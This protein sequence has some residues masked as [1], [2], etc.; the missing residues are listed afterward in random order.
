MRSL[1]ENLPVYKKAQDLVIY[2][3]KIVC[4]FSRYHKYTVG[5]ELRNLSRK[6]LILIARANIKQERKNTLSEVLEK[7]EEL[8]ILIR[9]CKEIKA[10]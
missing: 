10:F 3:E 2:F 5:T 8:K 7:L 9:I 6:I 1:Y 4:N